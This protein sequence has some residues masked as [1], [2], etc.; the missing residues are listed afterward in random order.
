MAHSLNTKVD[1]TTEAIAYLGF[2]KYGKVMLGDQAIEFYNEKNVEDN[3]NFPWNSLKAI[4]GDVSSKGQIGRNFYII[5]QNNKKIR[6]SSQETGK[7]LK[8]S[9]EYL[10]DKKVIRS[11]TMSSA[12]AGFFRH[13]K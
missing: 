6:F 10:G 12:I 4:Q 13:N 8:V 9:R 11:R 7:I 2:P 5:L 3:M 1:F